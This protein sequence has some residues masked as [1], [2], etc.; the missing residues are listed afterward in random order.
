MARTISNVGDGVS[1]VALVL[2]VQETERSGVAVGILLLAIGLPPL[3]S[4]FAGA[5]ADR[6]DQRRLMM[7]CD[8]TQTALFAAVAAIVPSYPGLVAVAVLSSTL[9]T[10]FGPAGASSLAA[11]V[12]RDELTTAN[13]WVGTS[14]NV[15]VILGPAIGGALF[16]TVGFRAALA[17]DAAS[18]L[19]S[20]LLLSRV[21][22]L[23]PVPDQERESGILRDTWRG[24]VE[25]MRNPVVRAVAVTLFV[26]V[27]FAAMDNV[28]LVFLAKE[29]GATDV[30]Y[31]L[32]VSSFGVGM[33]ISSL[34]LVRIGARTRTVPLLLVGWAMV[35]LGTLST[36]LVPVVAA[37]AVMQALAGA[38]NG[39]TNVA[40]NTLIQQH[41][42][43][44]QMGRAFGLTRVGAMVGGSVS[45]AVAGW[46]VDLTSP[47]TVFVIAGA[48]GLAVVALLWVLLPTSVRTGPTPPAPS[49]GP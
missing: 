1:T 21:P 35:G 10:L 49:P 5:I 9:A 32:L 25:G 7:A 48:G 6:V 29:R 31:G 3:L 23:P 14:L 15:R 20:F 26:G 34:T 17:L 2:R 12:R 38:G 45:A 46:L 16:G 18:F 43:R 24:V 30:A 44:P 36:A 41:V 42:L 39:T 22:A 19:A 27:A 4:P 28:A 8:A 13:A 11:L 33:L 47:A 40:D 37:M